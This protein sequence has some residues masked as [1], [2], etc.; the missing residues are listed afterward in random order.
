MLRAVVFDLDD[1]LLDEATAIR[2]AVSKWRTAIDREGSGSADDWAQIAGR[3]YQRYLDGGLTYREHG[4]SRVQEFL[5]GGVSDVEA[6]ELFETYL[7][8]YQGSWRL[9]D[10]ALPALRRARAAGLAVGVLTNG[11]AVQQ[12]LKMV[13]LGISNE[14]D[15]F[16]ASSDIG[17]AKPH[18]S[19]F[20]AIMERLGCDPHEALM[21]GDHPVNDVAGATGA[22][23]SAILIDRFDK[24]REAEYARASSLSEISFGTF[25][26]P[27]A[28]GGH[29]RV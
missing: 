20:R 4:R 17:V 10:D 28:V 23:L 11:D 16:L 14:V 1:T 5:G 21:V 3:Y 9:F 29:A 27:H 8:A 13:S 15:G 22:G 26:A 19:A 6:E 2:S 7:N 18:P 25:S 12:W 24:H